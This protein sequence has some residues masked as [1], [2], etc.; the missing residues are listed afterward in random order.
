MLKLLFFALLPSMFFL[1]S[2]RKNKEM[3][4]VKG[5]SFKFQ[6]QNY[7]TINSFYLSK[8]ELTMEEYDSFCVEEGRPL[9]D[10]KGWGRGNMPA[11]HLTWY[12][13]IEYCNW[14]SQKERFTPCYSIDKEASDKGLWAV[15]CDWAAD[16]Y[17]LPTEAEWE[18]AATGGR[19]SKG[20]EFAGSSDLSRV[21]W[22][23]LNANGRTHIIGGKKGNELGFYDM[24]GNVWEWCWFWHE[25][26]SKSE[27]RLLRGGSWRTN[28]FNCK[29]LN[30]IPDKPWAKE[31]EYGLRLARSVKK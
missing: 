16:G 8:Y 10:D 24:T 28:A 6:N 20:H 19:K 15:S 14:R 29:T 23:E 27:S 7:V 22:Y 9:I 4:L 17:R 12:D 13:A 18:Y 25:E 11:I 26:D 3:I 2:A 31:D 30:Y 1:P 5:G 21:A